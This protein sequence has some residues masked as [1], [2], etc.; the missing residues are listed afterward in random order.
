VRHGT[1]VAGTVGA[2]DNDI[3]V[4][5]VAPGARIHGVRVCDAVALADLGPCSPAST[6]RPASTTSTSSSSEH[7]AGVT[8]SRPADRSNPTEIG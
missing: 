7:P 1:H 8:R 5:G 4:V 6:S 2:L 3:G